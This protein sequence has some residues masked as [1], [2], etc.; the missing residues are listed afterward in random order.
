MIQND[1][2]SLVL[3]DFSVILHWREDKVLIA[4]GVPPIPLTTLMMDLQS[5]QNLIEFEIKLTE[6]RITYLDKKTNPCKNYDPK[7]LSYSQCVKDFI[8]AHS[9]ANMKCF[10]P[11][12][13]LSSVCSFSR[14]AL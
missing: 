13:Y 8:W 7:G 12:K 11:G 3:V 6:Q 2:C 4:M 9:K 1:L 10:L 14:V 5:Q